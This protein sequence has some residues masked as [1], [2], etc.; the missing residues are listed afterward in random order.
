[1]TWMLVGGFLGGHAIDAL[2]YRPMD[3]LAAPWR[4]LAIWQS[5]GSF[6]GF[7]GALIAV[8][9]WRRYQAIDGMKTP[10]GTLPRF[11]KR[12]AP[13]PLLPL[14]D[15]VLSVFPVAWIFGRAGCAVAHDHPGIRA[16]TGSL[17][18]V[19]AIVTGSVATLKVLLWQAE[20][21]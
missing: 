7:L 10:L 2:L 18:A 17:L 11:V 14:S 21:D 1:M 4:L 9:L 16:A 15:L 13:E 6:G 20:R 3:T 8:L 19:A 5:Q 12:P